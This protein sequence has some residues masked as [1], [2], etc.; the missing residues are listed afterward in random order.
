MPTF[1]DAILFALGFSLRSFTDH[2]VNALLAAR[3]HAVERCHPDISPEHIIFGVATLRRRCA[4]RAIL[5]NLGLNLAHEAKAIAALADFHSPGESYA[6]PRLGP[7]A[8]LLLSRAIEQARGLGVRYVA[9]EHLVL[10]LLDG[11]G[12]A[13]EFLRERG[14]TA[15][16]F[17][18][19]LEKLYAGSH[20][21]GGR[22]GH[23]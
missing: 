16:R 5:E 4:A 22:R 15:D 19:E 7:E 6:H 9:T 14:I 20:K 3:K 13:A 18:A 21:S 12:P 11:K 17:L 1:V 23:R 8:K 10:G 2:S